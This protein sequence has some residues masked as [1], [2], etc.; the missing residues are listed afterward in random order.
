MGNSES[1]QAPS[2]DKVKS[3]EREKSQT[4][5]TSTGSKPAA[6]PHQSRA[7]ASPSASIPSSTVPAPTSG[8]GQNRVRSA[9]AS[10]SKTVPDNMGQSESKTESKRPPSRSSTLPTRPPERDTP[11]QPID[12]PQP[13]GHDGGNDRAERTTPV[14]T[15]A[16]PFSLQPNFSRPPRLP[17]PIERDPEPSSPILAPIDPAVHVESEN[18]ILSHPS[19]VSSTTLDDEEDVADIEQ[20]V[21]ESNPLAQQVPTTLTWRGNAE[22]VYVT[23]TFANWDKKFRMR[24]DE[25]GVFNATM[26]LTTGTHHVT[27]LADG[28]S[29]VSQTLPTTV[30]FA[31]A[32][33]NYIEVTAPPAGSQGQQQPSEPVPIP[34]TATVAQDHAAG[35]DTIHGPTQGA[36][37][38]HELPPVRGETIMPPSKE[39]S[40]VPQQIPQPSTARPTPSRSHPHQQSEQPHQPT[41]QPRALRPRP[42]YTSQIPELLLH[43]DI[44]NN[45]QDERY[46]RASKAIA[47]L[48]PPPSLPM[49]MSKSILNAA[50]PH[51]DDASVLTMPNHTVLNHLATA[52]IRDGVLATS[53]TTRYKRKVSLPRLLKRAAVLFFW[54]NGGSF[55]H[56]SSPPSCTNPRPTTT[57]E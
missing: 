13:A 52:S 10:S 4:R 57:I 35:A 48:P 31:N 27:F 19:V 42:N 38:I 14:L 23:G 8:S 44:Y 50:M 17:L 22:A 43:H 21:A 45:K 40:S 37:S 56:S 24:K 28:E 49:F 41:A 29:S 6:S 5:S 9:T 20:F 55:V 53:G 46:I 54:A 15:S 12:V 30:D 18:A 36:E 32:L 1:S 33:V 3:K 16:S 2:K 7:H 47:D 39:P 34:G 26:P 11:A 51:K 25:E